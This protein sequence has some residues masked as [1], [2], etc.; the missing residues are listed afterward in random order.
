MLDDLL[1]VRSEER[2]LLATDETTDSAM[3]DALRENVSSR[4]EIM[5]LIYGSRIIA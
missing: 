2:S 5:Q 1:E 4:G 3:V